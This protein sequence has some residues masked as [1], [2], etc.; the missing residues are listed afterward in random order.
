MVTQSTICLLPEKFADIISNVIP[1]FINVFTR[2]LHYALT[3]HDNTI[4]VCMFSKYI[5]QAKN[6]IYKF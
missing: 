1:Y 2:A 4:T 6:M 3:V 5:V